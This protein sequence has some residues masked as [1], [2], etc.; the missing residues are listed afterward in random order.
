MRSL[1]CEMMADW[2][3]HRAEY[4]VGMVDLARNQKIGM[5]EL[6]P[7]KECRESHKAAGSLVRQL[8]HMG[9]AAVS[10]MAAE[11]GLAEEQRALRKMAEEVCGT[12]AGLENA[13]AVFATLDLDGSGY[14]CIREQTSALRSLLPDAS[15]RNLRF[16]LAMFYSS[17]IT[18]DGKLCLEELQ[19]MLAP[20]SSQV[21]ERS[22]IGHANQMETWGT[23][24]SD[25]SAEGTIFNQVRNLVKDNPG[26]LEEV[27]SAVTP[28]SEDSSLYSPEELVRITAA[29]M[30]GWGDKRA[31]HFVSMLT[32]GSAEPLSLPAVKDRL[33]GAHQAHKAAG[34][35]RRAAAESESPNAA[36]QP[37]KR[38]PSLVS[39]AAEYMGGDRILQMLADHARTPKG[40][41]DIAAAWADSTSAAPSASPSAPGPPGR[42]LQS[43]RVAAMLRVVPALQMPGSVSREQSQFVLAYLFA[44]NPSADGDVSGDALLDALRPF[45]SGMA[46]EEPP[47]VQNLYSRLLT[48]AKADPARLSTLCAA[49]IG[50]AQQST[51]ESLVSLAQ[52][53]EPK[54]MR[55]TGA[56]AHLAA[57]AGLPCEPPITDAD[58]L[59]VHLKTCREAHKRAAAAWRQ[60]ELGDSQGCVELGLEYAGNV[61]QVLGRVGSLL[62]GPQGTEAFQEYDTDGSGYLDQS[63][64]CRVVQQIDPHV[65]AGELRFLLAFA[66]QADQNGDGRLC[67][68]EAQHML[69]PFA[70]LLRTDGA[71]SE[72]VADA[73]RGGGAGASGLGSA[74]GETSAEASK[75][76]S[77]ASQDAAEMPAAAE[78]SVMEQYNK[79][80]PPLA[81]RDSGVDGGGRNLSYAEALVGQRAPPGGDAVSAPMGQV[82][83]EDAGREDGP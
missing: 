59:K 32:V 53:L 8:E 3:P 38:Q 30:K 37:R 7:L 10:S 2:P 6:Q 54:V 42:R 50:S 48:A 71:E 15:D 81:D 23:T 47:T 43:D 28:A 45:D 49:A 79:Q 62:T 17:D 65:T 34:V 75:G 78:A 35:L 76:G 74:R 44:T 63:E 31:D 82:S 25:G 64:L 40:A 80:L 73:P 61:S 27:A 72:I 39:G 19:E 68:R 18:Q 60:L 14:L 56:Q 26:I 5:E 67:L 20:F 66:V 11:D 22:Q 69:A 41:K 77:A 13:K 21:T 51:Q 12:E 52:E 24:P 9:A 58:S 57:M 70:E 4:V 83:G 46:H 55:Q 1:V 33:P 16:M 36:A 29:L